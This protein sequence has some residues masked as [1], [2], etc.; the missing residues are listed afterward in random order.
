[1][2]WKPLL[3]SSP[4]FLVLV[5]L[6]SLKLFL[7]WPVWPAWVSSHAYVGSHHQ[8]VPSTTQHQVLNFFESVKVGTLGHCE[9]Q[10]AVTQVEHIGLNLILSSPVPA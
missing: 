9:E 10:V 8:Q 7:A 6:L 1:M 5:S 3:F 4:V 2:T